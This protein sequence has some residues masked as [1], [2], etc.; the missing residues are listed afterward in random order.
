MTFSGVKSDL[1]L[2]DQ[3]VTWKKLVILFHLPQVSWWKLKKRSFE[4]STRLTEV[5]NM[6][7]MKLIDWLSLRTVILFFG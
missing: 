2:G 6:L 1:H 3:E 5:H 4:V 7:V